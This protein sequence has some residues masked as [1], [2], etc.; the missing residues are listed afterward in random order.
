MNNSN[1]I[2]TNNSE[3]FAQLLAQHQVTPAPQGNSLIDGTVVSVTRDGAYIDYGGKF[4]GIVPTD[5]LALAPLKLGDRKQFLVVAPQDDNGH[6]LLSSRAAAMWNEAKEAFESSRVVTVHVFAVARRKG[7]QSALGLRVKLGDL[8]GFIPRS[9]L[10][11]SY[12][13]LDS[14]VGAELQ[15]KIIDFSVSERKLVFDH[16]SIARQEQA[17]HRDEVLATLTP[18]ATVTGKLARV[19]AKDGQEF[20]FFVDF[21]AGISG[22]LHR[23][24]IA[25]SFQ[26]PLR[27]VLATGSEVA[28]K[29]LSVS[30]QGDKIRIALSHRAALR[31]EIS[32]KLKVGDMITV[33]VCRVV[34]FGCF[35]EIVPGVDALLHKN[36]FASSMR[37]YGNGPQVADE[38]T[39]RVESCDIKTGRIGVTQ[40]G[41]TT[42]A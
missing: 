2:V 5:E 24:E 41:V 42:A 29:V 3:L 4:D 15:V 33:R 36:C 34:D 19:A 37:G 30:G 16:A 20:G 38:L 25:G 40:A 12:S 9:K 26:K 32:R 18:G 23:S 10:Q 1:S 11:A 6:V 31:E 17:A 27:E 7:T 8:R 39:V 13:A 28:L 22:L 21:G 35:V 14:L